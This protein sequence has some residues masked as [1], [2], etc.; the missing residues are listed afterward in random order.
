[1][2]KAPLKSEPEA[3]EATGKSSATAKK[4]RK[5][6]R[7]KLYAALSL[8]AVLAGLLVWQLAR[9]SAL[10]DDHAADLK[11]VN[12]HNAETLDAQASQLLRT[13]G[14]LLRW[15]IAAP[16][17]AE[18]FDAIEAQIK[19]LVREESIMIVAIAD[20]TGTVR[21]ATNHKLE[22]K[23]LDVAFAGLPDAQSDI[24]VS[25]LEA[26]LIAVVPVF[27]QGQPVGKAVISYEHRHDANKE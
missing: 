3:K 21:L 4:P 10:K 13:S 22:G 8:S 14:S 23:S 2:K 27:E 25:H 24:V 9:I 16:L 15:A 19:P 5:H 1:M 6:Q 20:R 11:R 17:A 18:N 12:A 26:G 7:L